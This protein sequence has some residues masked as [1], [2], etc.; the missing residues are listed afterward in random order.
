M[1]RQLIINTRSDCCRTMQMMLPIWSVNVY[2]K[3]FWQTLQNT[4]IQ[5]QRKLPK[6]NRLKFEEKKNVALEVSNCPNI[7]CM[8]NL[9]G[10][11]AVCENF[12][13]KAISWGVGFTLIHKFSNPQNVPKRSSRTP[14][15][16]I[17]K[18]NQQ[19]FDFIS[20]DSLLV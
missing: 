12:C 7:R 17:N 3:K 5:K 6:R 13:F 8:N 1:K 9:W 18:E 19:L 2:A 15:Y 14:I 4:C 11:F 20:L 16:K 10:L